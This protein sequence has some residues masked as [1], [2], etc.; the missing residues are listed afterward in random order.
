MIF[1]TLAPKTTTIHIVLPLQLL[2]HYCRVHGANTALMTVRTA[3]TALTHNANHYMPGHKNR[4]RIPK[5]KKE[6][7]RKCAISLY[8]GGCTAYTHGFTCEEGECF[9]KKVFVGNARLHGGKD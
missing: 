6:R 7:K 5:F 2:N 1:L 9:L 3:T 8:T 4:I